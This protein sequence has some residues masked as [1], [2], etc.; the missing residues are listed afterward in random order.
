M[1]VYVDQKHSLIAL[2][3]FLDT[4][5]PGAGA[6]V[7]GQIDVPRGTRYVT[8]WISY[9]RGGAGGS[10]VFRAS[11]R[12]SGASAWARMPLVDPS[13]LVTAAPNAS[14]NFY[15]EDH[16]GPAPA[17]GN[18]ITYDLTFELPMNTT[19]VQL[20]VAELGAVATPGT[21][22]VQTTGAGG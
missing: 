9:T 22:L 7:A 11:S 17:D 14:Q 15:Q 2:A 18:P 8:F 5:L 1:T 6:F 10:P 12:P 3:D 13:S 19:T 20:E 16:N 4:A 21:V